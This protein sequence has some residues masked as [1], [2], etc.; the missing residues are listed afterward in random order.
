MIF[1]FQ[2]MKEPSLS[3]CEEIM[4]ELQLRN[5]LRRKEENQGANGHLC[6]FTRVFFTRLLH[7]TWK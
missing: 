3:T 4:R 5:T 2:R 6:S 1:I 7:R